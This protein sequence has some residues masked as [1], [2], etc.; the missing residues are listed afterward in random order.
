MKRLFGC[1]VVMLAFLVVL[2]TILACGTGLYSTPASTSTPVTLAEPT[3]EPEHTAVPT[4]EHSPTPTTVPPTPVP[5]LT[6]EGTPTATPPPTATEEAP[7]P[8]PEPSPT[9]EAPTTTPLVSQVPPRLTVAVQSLTGETLNSVM[10]GNGLLLVAGLDN[11]TDTSIKDTVR[12]DLDPIAEPITTCRLQA[13][14]GSTGTCS[15]TVA[16]DGWAWQD[17][18][19][20]QQRTL[21]ATLEQYQ[22]A[23]SVSV[24]V[25]PKPVVLVHG[26]NSGAWAWQAWTSADGFLPARGLQSFAVGD[27]Q[28]GIE[29]MNIG[30]FHQPRRPTRSIAGNAA[31]LARYVE[32]ARRATGAERVDI[33]A[34]SMGGLISRHYIATLMPVVERSG[35]PPA[36]VVNQLYMLGTPNAGTTCAILPAILGLYAPASTQMTPSYAQHIFN[37]EINDSR[38]VPFFVLAGD[39]IHDYTALVCT[40]VPTDV[41]VSVASATTA[42]PVIATQMPVLH[43][44]QIKSPEVFDTVFRSLARSADEYPISLPTEPAPSPEDTSSLQIAALQSGT[45]DSDKPTTLRLDVDQTEALSIVLYSPTQDVDMAITTSRDRE[46][47]PDTAPELPDVT[48]RKEDDPSTPATKGFRITRPEKGAWE[49]QLTPTAKLPKEGSLWAVAVF[50]QSDRRLVAEAQPAVVQPGQAVVLRAVLTGPSD[51][52][53]TK[54][55]A[56]IRDAGGQVV[57]KASL[58]D[59]GA[60]EDDKAGDRVF[61]GTWTAPTA[62][63]YTIAINAVGRQTNGNA[64]QRVAVIAVQAN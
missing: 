48:L 19:R 2:A 64:F 28:F 35:L 46:I 43:G 60:H 29:P 53:S 25:Q 9:R 8:S 1:A 23:A 33:V 61:G 52:T 54:V 47:R 13:P 44:E 14:P 30:D 39:P 27:G 62:G 4:P 11:P 37:R 32:A 20:V 40:A 31:I 24:S 16:A 5:S 7:T 22:L 59:D 41:Y 38:S 21:L 57:A 10:D 56:V 50:V 34:H 6:T 58:F 49:V 12:F 18:R 17:H 3:T 26:T 63:L 51:V 55:K 15:A 42:I 36:P 45:L